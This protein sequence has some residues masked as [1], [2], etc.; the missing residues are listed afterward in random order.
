MRSSLAAVLSV[1]VAAPLAH[2][3]TAAPEDSCETVTT[4][5][6]TGNAAPLALPYNQQ[7]GQPVHIP[8]PVVPPP[9]VLPPVPAPPDACNECAEPPRARAPVGLPPALSGRWQLQIDENGAAYTRLRSTPSAA[10]W[11][12]GLTLWLGSYVASMAVGISHDGNPYTAIPIFGALGTGIVAGLGGDGVGA[13][14]GYT[15]GGIAQIAGMVTFIAGLAAGPKK[16]ERMPVQIAPMAS[17][18]GGGFSLAMKF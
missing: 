12:P 3:Q 18:D 13:A 8:P 17:R 2:A 7:A 5:R 1:L 14:V 9:D 4:V 6:C 10:V 16:L 11:V 15:F